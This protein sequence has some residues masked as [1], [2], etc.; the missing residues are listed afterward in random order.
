MTCRE[1]VFSENALDFLVRNYRGEDYVRQIYQQDCYLP[2]GNSQAVIYKEASVINSEAIQ[3]FGFS[4]I[5]NVYGLMSEEALEE[6]GVLRIRRQPYLDLYGQGV[7]IGFVDTG[8]RVIIL[9][10]Q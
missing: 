7:L 1:A 8:E 5:P 9:S 6:S 3:R 2:L 10:S 4:A